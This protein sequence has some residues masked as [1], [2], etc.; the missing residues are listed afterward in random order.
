MATFKFSN[1]FNP[2]ELNYCLVKVTVKV[3]SYKDSK[4]KYYDITYENKYA[5]KKSIFLHPLFDT[6]S[7][8]GEIIVKNPLTEKLVE[9]LLMDYK[10]LEKFSGNST[11]Q[12]Y[13]GSIMRMISELWD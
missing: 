7:L 6:D 2:N 9:F 1:E 8:D 4:C 5:N 11:A 10:T 3:I 12:C 13:K